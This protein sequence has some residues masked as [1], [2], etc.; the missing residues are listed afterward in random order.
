MIERWADAYNRK[1]NVDQIRRDELLMAIKVIFGRMEDNTKLTKSGYL[2][3]GSTEKGD[4]INVVW[5]KSNLALVKG[6][7]DAAPYI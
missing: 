2:P 7:E 6:L 3:A 5:L 4:H 1:E